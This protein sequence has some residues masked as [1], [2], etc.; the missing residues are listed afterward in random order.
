MVAELLALSLRFRLG[1]FVVNRRLWV[2]KAKFMV[3]QPFELVASI[4]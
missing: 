1:F 3:I 4:P 2:V